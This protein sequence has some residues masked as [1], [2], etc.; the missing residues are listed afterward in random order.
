MAKRIS[1]L[2]WLRA[3]DR[4]RAAARSERRKADRIA[5]KPPKKRSQPKFYQTREWKQLR[6]EILVQRGNRCEC[7]GASPKDG[8][9]INVDHIVAISRDW[10]RRL[11]ATNLQI[12]CGSCN[13]GKGSRNE[14]WRVA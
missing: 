8:V 6:Y 3:E 14:D 10:S 7:C 9:K 11:D 12:L 2:L 1:G 5:K 4:R 13:Q